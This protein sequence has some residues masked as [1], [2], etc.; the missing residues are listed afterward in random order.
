M[1]KCITNKTLS[2]C[3]KAKHR[4]FPLMWKEKCKVYTTGILRK[5]YK[6]GCWKFVEV[7][8]NDDCIDIENT[9]TTN[10]NE[11]FRQ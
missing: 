6:N 7:V 9:K 2:F 8:S 1:E 5:L 11:M 3:S 4:Q 10:K